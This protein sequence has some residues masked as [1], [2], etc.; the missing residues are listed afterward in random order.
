MI[1]GFQRITMTEATISDAKSPETTRRMLRYGGWAVLLFL[2]GW[3]FLGPT[4]TG[5][6]EGADLQHRIV[7][8]PVVPAATVAATDQLADPNVFTAESMG[9]AWP[10]TGISRATVECR[11]G[12]AVVVADN[13][14]T[15]ALDGQ[16]NAAARTGKED[17]IR[18]DAIRRR[19]SPTS[20]TMVAL[21]PLIERASALCGN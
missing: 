1:G 10:F 14:T 2:V 3:L 15:Y 6:V 7:E 4:R 19:S 17:F 16:A 11:K 13:G 8:E 20:R 12:M 18:I 5:R 21:D 9:D